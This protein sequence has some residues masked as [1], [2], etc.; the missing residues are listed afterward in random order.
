MIPETPNSAVWEESVLGNVHHK[1]AFS[2]C[3]YEFDVHPRLELSSYFQSSNFKKEQT[4]KEEVYS[5]DEYKK[6]LLIATPH[7]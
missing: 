7:V 3:R 2:Y 5:T 1:P 6:T 4:Q